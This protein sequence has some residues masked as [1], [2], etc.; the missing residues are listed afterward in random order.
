M[1]RMQLNRQHR[2]TLASGKSK[3]TTIHGTKAHALKR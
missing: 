2:F 3:A 1:L